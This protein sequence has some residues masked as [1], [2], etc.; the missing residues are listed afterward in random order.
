MSAVS[1]DLEGSIAALESQTG[2]LM[3][4]KTNIGT[5]IQGNETIAVIAGLGQLSSKMEA[6][7][8][9]MFGCGT[10]GPQMQLNV[11][12]KL[13]RVNLFC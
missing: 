11:M 1:N 6:E 2:V 3:E 10:S 4:A 8:W 7:K 5:M 12:S 9:L 13:L